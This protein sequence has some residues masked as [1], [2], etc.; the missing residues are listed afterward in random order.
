[1]VAN[2][3]RAAGAQHLSI[4]HRAAGRDALV[5][6]TAAR[7]SRRACSRFRES[8]APDTLLSINMRVTHS[9]HAFTWQ[10][11]VCTRANT[12]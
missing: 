7:G 10:K 4:R 11:K 5:H 12:P 2:W 3:H 8:A 9:E 6:P 1:M